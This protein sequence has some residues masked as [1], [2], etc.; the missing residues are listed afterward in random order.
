MALESN[1]SKSEKPDKSISDYSEE[2]LT[3]ILISLEGDVES[4]EY[5]EK[6][7]ILNIVKFFSAT[8]MYDENS[9]Y[10]QL[11][12]AGAFYH[13]SVIYIAMQD[14]GRP[15]LKPLIDLNDEEKKKVFDESINFYK[16]VRELT[17]ILAQRSIDYLMQSAET[18]SDEISIH[19]DGMNF[20]ELLDSCFNAL[21]QRPVI[22]SAVYRECLDQIEDVVKGLVPLITF[23][24]ATSLKNY[25]CD[26][27]NRPSFS[28]EDFRLEYQ[29]SLAYL[30]ELESIDL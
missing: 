26:K 24:E 9:I 30:K 21:V 12:S 16:Y 6:K 19:I 15:N 29:K 13:D 20:D 14:A 10:K 25:D 2:E 22:Y 3:D 23:S 27:E 1:D 7:I 17:S 8:G 18:A 11:E 5:N 28:Y 4:E